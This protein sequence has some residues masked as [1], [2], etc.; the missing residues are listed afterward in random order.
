MSEAA[1]TAVA[2]RNVGALLDIVLLQRIEMQVDATYA[3]KV[4]ARYAL[5]AACVMV[6]SNILDIGWS[7]EQWLVAALGVGLGF[8]LQEIFANFVS[9]LIILA[10]RP[11]P[12]VRRL[13]RQAGARA[14]RDQ[15]RGGRRAAGKGHQ[16]PIGLTAIGPRYDKFMRRGI[17]RR[18]SFHV[19]PLPRNSAG[20]IPDQRLKAR[21]NPLIPA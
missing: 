11:I 15:P 12:R 17:S 7:D 14:A 10:E 18:E 2:V 16:D 1:L 3:I 13:V 5:A 8:G 9:G 6:A 19:C 4:V 20:V 21:S